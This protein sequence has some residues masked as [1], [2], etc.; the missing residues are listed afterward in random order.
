MNI[1][2]W[3]SIVIFDGRHVITTLLSGSQ[4]IRNESHNG[5]IGTYADDDD[6]DDY[7]E[8]I[9]SI[10]YILLRCANE[11]LNWLFFQCG[12]PQ[13]QYGRKQ[14]IHSV[15]HIFHHIS[16][17]IFPRFF[18]FVFSFFVFFLYF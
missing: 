13:I 7:N 5:A 14:L 1:H 16:T 12:S 4:V 10:L 6:D 18:D 11:R 15:I 2:N 3:H 8:L 17:S 9:L